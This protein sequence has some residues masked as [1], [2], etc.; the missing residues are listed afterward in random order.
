MLVTNVAIDKFTK[1]KDSLRQAQASA[2]DMK[3]I[4]GDLITKSRE[5]LRTFISQ[6]NSPGDIFHDFKISNNKAI[7]ASSAYFLASSYKYSEEKHTS[8]NS[9]SKQTLGL[10]RV[11]A[12]YANGIYSKKISP[13]LGLIR[14]FKQQHY[15]GVLVP[16]HGI[17]KND[18]TKLCDKTFK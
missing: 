4:T 6:N 12:Q 9:I 5:L 3:H 15:N 8:S 13:T 2:I 14:L 16:V 10:E 17:F 11:F 18:D 7:L 1:T